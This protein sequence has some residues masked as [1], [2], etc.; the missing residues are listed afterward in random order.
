ML[1]AIVAVY[2]DWGIGRKGTQP[3]VLRAD[4]RH[5]RQ[6]TG[7]AVSGDADIVLHDHQPASA[8]ATTVSGHVQISC[9]EGPH[10]AQISLKSV[11]GNIKVM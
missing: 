4:R 10:A 11:S 5:F 2:A 8:R 7:S 1:E 9:Q 3:V 6:I